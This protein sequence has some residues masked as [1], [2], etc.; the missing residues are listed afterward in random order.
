MESSTIH[1]ILMKD[2]F[3]RK[4]FKGFSTPDVKLPK[5]IKTPA[6]Y[7][8]NTDKSDGPGI[9]WCIVVFTNKKICE[10]FD[11]LGKKPETYGFDKP[12]LERCSY[13]NYNEFP[14]Q[15]VTAATCGHH[16]IFFAYQRARK[17][18]PRQIMRK[19]SSTN[20]VR[21]DHMVFNFIA[22]KFGKTF[23]KITPPRHF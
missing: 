4:I 20:L 21:N 6:L 10:F 14:V 13:I 8:L 9:H 3:T 19:F 16:C 17:L 12:I 2:P 22:K 7:V 23:A 11:P 18:T 5:I 1:A 15:D